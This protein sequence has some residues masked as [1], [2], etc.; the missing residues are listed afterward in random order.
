MGGPS[1]TELRPTIFLVCCHKLYR[2]QLRKILKKQKRMTAYEYQFVVLVDP[3]ENLSPNGLGDIHETSQ[4]LVEAFV[5][6][7]KTSWCGLKARAQSLAHQE[8]INFT[9]GGIL[10]IDGDAFGLT[11]KLGIE[12]LV[13]VDDASNDADDD[14]DDDSAVEDSCSPFITFQDSRSIQT[15]DHVETERRAPVFGSRTTAPQSC[16]S[17]VHNIAPKRIQ[18]GS[19]W[20][21]FGQPHAPNVVGSKISCGR[22]DWSLV[23]FEPRCEVS[24][25]SLVN[26]LVT[27][28]NDHLETTCFL[29][30]SAMTGGEVWTNAGLAGPV[31]GWLVDCPALLHR[32]GKSFEVLQVVGRCEGRMPIR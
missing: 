28:I 3:V 30:R 14:D 31:K 9:I 15:Q 4:I 7:G 6:S 13:P 2:K 16:T 11:V 12:T 17:L 32:H 20:R 8:P 25:S 23:K 10:F 18:C 22:L 27:P 26:T 1:P 29:N 5:P 21:H 24:H 19:E